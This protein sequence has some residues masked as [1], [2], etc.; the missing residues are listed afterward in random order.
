MK[1]LYTLPTDNVILECLANDTLDRNGDVVRFCTILDTLH[2]CT[3]LALDGVWGSGKT[4]FIKQ[5]KM[6][7]D[8]IC[9]GPINDPNIKEG[10][11]GVLSTYR[12]IYSSINLTQCHSTIYFDAWLND[13]ESDPILS[14]I[15]AIVKSEQVLLRI[16]NE[17]N[18]AKLLSSILECISGRNVTELFEAAKGD[19]L[20][21]EIKQNESIEK[22]MK[23]FFSAAIGEK[24]NRLIVF[25]DE[26]DRCKPTYAISLLERIKHFFTDE[27]L[28]FVFSV[29][30]NQLQHT[31]KS[32]YGYGI[33]ASKYLEKMFDIS[34][35]LPEANTEKFMQH[36]GFK[37][38]RSYF[39]KIC[40]SV[41]RYFNFGLRDIAKYR[42]YLEAT[43][44]KIPH[45]NSLLN[46]VAFD[47]AQTY[48]LICIAPILIGLRIYDISS[49][50]ML[51]LGSNSKPFI[52]IMVSQD[53]HYMQY[54][55]LVGNNEC[56]VIS[57][58]DSTSTN[59]NSRVPIELSTRLSELY[60]ALFVEKYHDNH[61]KTIGM[62]TIDREVRDRLLKYI[63]PLSKFAKANAEIHI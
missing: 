22:L 8:G 5:V 2:E 20:M 21:L 62:I 44:S 24:N 42:Q 17:K 6:L 36:I 60:S 27:R 61:E 3:V 55:Y 38:S 37:D 15:N 23:E 13:N 59:A 4:F 58:V 48:C 9:N 63:N 45:N 1:R 52:D 35:P 34:I 57:S 46:T 40:N 14:I 11:N 50:N 26:L 33:D 30:Q 56:L 47:R 49:F 53:F 7:I 41:I 54:D 51:I 10:L 18:L 28:T 43:I 19:D 31:I 32:Y 16:R 29:N 12:S 25:I 39:G